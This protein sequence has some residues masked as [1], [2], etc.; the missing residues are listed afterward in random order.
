MKLTKDNFWVDDAWENSRYTDHLTIE[1]STKDKPKAEALVK[2]I[3]KNQED[4]EKWDLVSRDLEVEEAKN[5]LI[6]ERLEKFFNENNV[7]TKSEYKQKIL[8]GEIHEVEE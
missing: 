3:L 4:A 2:Q 5:T 6:V 8:K 7:L 1:C